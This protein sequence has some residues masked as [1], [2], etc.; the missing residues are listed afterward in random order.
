[1]KCIMVPCLEVNRLEVEI[2]DIVGEFCITPDD[3]QQVYEKIHPALHEGR[4]VL[5]NFG[6]VRV[7][8]SPFLNMAVGQLLQDVPYDDVN[9][10]LQ[11]KGLTHHDDTLLR[12]V[13]EN[14]RDY[15][16]DPVARRALDRAIANAAEEM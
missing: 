5:L 15:Y 1:M 10:C 16:S 8:A 13:V 3:G 11:T 12:R 7:L 4:A 9:R 14:A 6:G 2:A